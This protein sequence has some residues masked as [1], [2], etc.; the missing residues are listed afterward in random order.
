MIEE[1]YLYGRATCRHGGE[2]MA[3]R[4]PGQLDKDVDSIRKDHMAKFG[5]RFHRHRI[6]DNAPWIICAC[7]CVTNSIEALREFGGHCARRI[8]DD[9][10]AL[11]VVRLENSP[12]HIADG[13]VIHERTVV[14][15]ANFPLAV[16][17][18]D[19]MGRNWNGVGH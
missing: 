12:H 11:P 18:V 1:A 9:F 4:K 10:E 19:E 3:G 14:A 6:E 8:T 5:V 7:R 17:P 16:P 15:D 2:A 13:I